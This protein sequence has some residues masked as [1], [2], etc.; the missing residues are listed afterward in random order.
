[1]MYAMT[2]RLSILFEKHFENI[3]ATY[4][5]Q[6]TAAGCKSKRFQLN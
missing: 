2:D 5:T 6:K 4:E 3:L 1:M